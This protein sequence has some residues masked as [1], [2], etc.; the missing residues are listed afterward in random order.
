MNET[1]REKSLI[2]MSQRAIEHC[3][4][5]KQVLSS[6]SRAETMDLVMIDAMLAL[7]TSLHASATH[8]EATMESFRV[9]GDKNFMSIALSTVLGL[10]TNDFTSDK[11]LVR[12]VRLDGS[13]DLQPYVEDDFIGNKGAYSDCGPHG[14]HRNG[15]DFGYEL[16][17]ELSC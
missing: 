11:A 3:D 2:I 7:I 8:A 16:T 4:P 14:P 12:P 10:P 1:E 5:H 13:P 9:D 17:C 6:I 15:T